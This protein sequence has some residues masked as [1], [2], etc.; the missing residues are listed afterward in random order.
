MDRT[1]KQMLN[2]VIILTGE[3]EEYILKT[4]EET[5]LSLEVLLDVLTVHRVRAMV[6]RNCAFCSYRVTCAKIP[7]LRSLCTACAPVDM[8]TLTKL[9]VFR[10]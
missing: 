8:G 3:S 4:L 2:D 9:E 6:K 7:E 1:R 10:D 5:R